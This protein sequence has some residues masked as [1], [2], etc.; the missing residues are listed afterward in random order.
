MKYRCRLEIIVDIL[1]VTVK[2][3]KKTKIMYIANLSYQLL[4]KYLEETIGLGFVCFGN[5]CYEITEK[6]RDFLE[7]YNDFSR[8]YQKIDR[9][10]QKML[11]ERETLEKRCERV[12]SV[13]LGAVSARRRRT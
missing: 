13:P 6:G 7:K 8:K 12:T 10:F 4:E 3:A 5:N 9:E 1:S 11:F 2:G